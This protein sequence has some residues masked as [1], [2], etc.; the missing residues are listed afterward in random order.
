ML[1]RLNYQGSRSGGSLLQDNNNF[2]HGRN[3]PPQCVYQI[4]QSINVVPTVSTTSW[5]GRQTAK[6]QQCTIQATPSPSTT[7]TQAIRQPTLWF[8]VV[9]CRTA[10]MTMGLEV[11]AAWSERP[12]PTTSGRLVQTTRAEHVCLTCLQ[13]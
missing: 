9:S 1:R 5:A 10:S 6:S 7:D 3:Q 4:A 13:R 8:M 2:L 12:L 11:Q